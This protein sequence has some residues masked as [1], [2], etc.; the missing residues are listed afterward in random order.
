MLKKSSE[1]VNMVTLADLIP[2]WGQTDAFE[3]TWMKALKEA[4]N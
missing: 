3:E 2:G 4:G 1:P